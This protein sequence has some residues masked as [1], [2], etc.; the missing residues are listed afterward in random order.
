MDENKEVNTSDD[1]AKSQ[2]TNQVK[3][4]SKQQS[5]ELARTNVDVGINTLNLFDEKQLAAAEVFLGKVMKSNKGGITSVADG[6]AVLMRAN[7]LGLPFSTCIEHIHVINGKT[8]VDIHIVKALLSRAGCTWRLT[9]DYQPLYEYTDG[10]NVY[11]DGSFPEYVKRC[12]SKE[13]AEANAAATESVDYVYVYPVMFYKDFKGN[14]Y[15]DYQIV[16]EKMGIV[17]N[18]AQVEFVTKQNKVPIYRIPAIPVDYVTEYEITRTKN[19]KETTATG[20]FSYSEAHTADLFTKD[21]Y[22]KYARVLIGHRAFTYAAREVASDILF[23][24]SETT[25]LKI[26]SGVELKGKDFD[27]SDEETEY[28]EV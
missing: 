6:L 25:E 21:T 13:E 23:G 7:D 3:T 5:T 19:G 27:S 12:K 22:V 17:I 11:N 20:R 8:G 10:I 9:K 26:V 18:R 28:I 14:V 2:A 4:E 24:V 15:R 16:P 1:V